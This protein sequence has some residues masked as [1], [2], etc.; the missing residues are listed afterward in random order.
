MTNVKSYTV[1]F[2]V[3]SDKKETF[4]EV[5]SSISTIISENSGKVVKE[6]EMGEK[7]LGHLVK[8]KKEGIYYEVS[9]TAP[10][11]SVAK[12]TR[13]FQINTDIL[14]TLMSTAGK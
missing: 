4:Q 7:K 13:Q 6:T 14:R 8:K 2:I 9:F 1:L 3:S 10:A 5:K 11:A 12:M